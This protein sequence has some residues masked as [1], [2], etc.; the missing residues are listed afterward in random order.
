MSAATRLWHRWKRRAGVRRETRLERRY[1]PALVK[2]A[3]DHFEYAMGLTSGE[4]L[5]F[6]ECY[7]H[8]SWVTLQTDYGWGHPTLRME[9]GKP[10]EVLAGFPCPRGVTIPLRSIA[11]VADAPDGS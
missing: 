5:T 10:R 7:L 6:S 1:G 11:W 4:V 9:A 3:S 2:A 8:G